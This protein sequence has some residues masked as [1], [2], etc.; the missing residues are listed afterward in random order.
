MLF[1]H[2]SSCPITPKKNNFYNLNIDKCSNESTGQCNSSYS[3]YQESEKDLKDGPEQD[4]DDEDFVQKTVDNNNL[5][6]IK[7]KHKFSRLHKLEL[8]N[9]KSIPVSL[10]YSLSKDRGVFLKEFNNKS[11]VYL[12]HNN[13]NGKQYVGSGID[14]RKILS[15]YYFPSRLMDGRH[16][17]NSLL[18]YGHDSFSVVILDVLG[19]TASCDKIELIGK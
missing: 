17:S 12:L 16:I 6:T 19:I 9:L 15:T 14:L 18:K 11:G 8:A 3:P 2:K 4:P 13:A 5:V 1:A 10:L 7:P